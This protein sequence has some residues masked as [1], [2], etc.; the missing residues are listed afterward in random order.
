MVTG[1]V[2]RVVSVVSRTWITMRAEIDQDTVDTTML[3]NEKTV[4]SACDQ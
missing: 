2:R 4:F 3:T 1:Q